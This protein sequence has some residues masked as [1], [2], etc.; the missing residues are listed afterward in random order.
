MHYLQYAFYLKIPDLITIT[1]LF[2]GWAGAP[3]PPPPVVTPL[4]LLLAL[5][6][7]L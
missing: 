3:Q 6:L 5:N 7:C 2:G 1:K 4:S